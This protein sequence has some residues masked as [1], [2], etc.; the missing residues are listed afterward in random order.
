MDPK[1]FKAVLGQFLSG[2][3]VVTAVRPDDQGAP[4]LHGMTASAFMSV[5]LDPPLVVVSVQNKAHMHGHL[6]GG[7]PWAVSFLAQGHDLVSNHFA[8]WESPDFTPTLAEGR[9]RT[10]VIAG[11]LG[12]LDLDLQDAIE[13]GDHTLFLGRVVDLGLAEEPLPGP[14]AYFRGKYGSFTA[15]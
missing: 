1:R 6:A 12:W 3:T 4:A 14:L 10:P 13:A 9:F 15:G 11:A 7:G 5:S 8:G 2:V